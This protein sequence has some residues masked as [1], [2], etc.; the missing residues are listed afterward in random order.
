MSTVI[1]ETNRISQIWVLLG[2]AEGSN[3]RQYT[4]MIG[5]QQ[6]NCG[7]GLKKGYTSENLRVVISGCP[8]NP[9][10]QTL[11]RAWLAGECHRVDA[12]ANLWV[13]IWTPLWEPRSRLSPLIP[14]PNP[15]VFRDF[16]TSPRRLQCWLVKIPGPLQLNVCQNVLLHEALTNKGMK[17]E[18][19]IIIEGQLRTL[20]YEHLPSVQ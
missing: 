5:C 14:K 1:N 13:E 11:Q 10:T 8:L 9:Q 2:I 17:L 15:H 18:A 16:T 20:V 19:G 6:N 12:L 4:K 7:R 3:Q